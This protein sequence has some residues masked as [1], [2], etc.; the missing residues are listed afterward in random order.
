MVHPQEHRQHKDCVNWTHLGVHPIG[1]HM[2]RL[3]PQKSYL[4]AERCN[5]PKRTRVVYAAAQ[6]RNAMDA[7]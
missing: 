6:V 7:T 5:Q 4:F 1:P 3:L 2:H